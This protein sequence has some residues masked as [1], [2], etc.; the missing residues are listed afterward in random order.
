MWFWTLTLLGFAGL[1]LLIAK[2]TRSDRAL[3]LLCLLVLAAWAVGSIVTS[4]LGGW[5]GL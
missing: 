3:I 2:A 1:G 5:D 4:D